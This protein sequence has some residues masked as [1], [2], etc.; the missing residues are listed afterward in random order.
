MRRGHGAEDCR[1]RALRGRLCALTR[2][3][4]ALPCRI[5]ALSPP[6]PHNAAPLQQRA[7]Q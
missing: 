2:R 4:R 3:M 5:R 1:I 6:R 7:A